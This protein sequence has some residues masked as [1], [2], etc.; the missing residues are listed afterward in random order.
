MGYEA[1]QLSLKGKK[2][3]VLDG[4]TGEQRYFLSFAQIFRGKYRDGLL[5]ELV[6]SDVH[7]PSYFRVNGPVRNMDE[8]YAAFDVKPGDKLYLKPEER[9]AIW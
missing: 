4:L 1:Y 2:A 9:V 6:L 3:P 7:S 5:R 8:W